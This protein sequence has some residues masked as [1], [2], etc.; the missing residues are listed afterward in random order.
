MS[1]GDDS[2]ALRLAHLH[3]SIPD[4]FW[5]EGTQALRD[6]TGVKAGKAARD[7]VRPSQAP[8]AP[9]L[10][11]GKLR[12][13]QRLPRGLGQQV[14]YRVPHVFMFRSEFVEMLNR[15]NAT[16]GIILPRVVTG[17]GLQADTPSRHRQRIRIRRRKS[18]AAAGLRTNPAFL[19]FA[20]AIAVLAAL[21]W[22]WMTSRRPE[23]TPDA[24]QVGQQAVALGALGRPDGLFRC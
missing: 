9:P 7:P 23:R 12:R 19:L 15:P 13:L 3:L 4:G 6:F 1:G 10:C 22:L 11:R 18:H 14:S 2:P 17:C 20:I 5:Q 24:I 16:G 8:S 21:L